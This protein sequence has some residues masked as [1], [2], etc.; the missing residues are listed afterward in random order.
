[1][2]KSPLGKRRGRPPASESPLAVD[3]ALWAALRSFA[4]KGFDGCSV[5]QLARELGV[6]HNL[7]HQ[8]FGSKEAL[9]HA[10]V[11][12]G[13]GRLVDA[14]TDDGEELPPDPLELLRTVLVR[15]I[16]A[17]AAHPELIQLMNVEG[18]ID[19]PRLRY[20][21]HRY[22]RPTEEPLL[23]LLRGLAA[24][25]RI[26]P[27]RLPTLRFLAVNGSVAPFAQRPLAQLL[28]PADPFGPEAIDAHAQDVADLLL[29]GLRP[30]PIPPRPQEHL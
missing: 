3:D 18:A 19:G 21:V 6:S 10:A 30:D 20:I 5:Q 4:A 24:E 8:R 28:D 15:Y 22:I 16:R 2:P 12:W 11:D 26:R 1:M 29:A 25:G 7:L 13:F 27:V 17:I 23:E 14:L 9:W